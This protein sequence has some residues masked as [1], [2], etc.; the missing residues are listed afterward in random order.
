[1]RDGLLVQ[2]FPGME[3]G[4]AASFSSLR[5]EGRYNANM[6]RVFQSVA[7]RRFTVEEYHRMAETGIL[8]PDER[9]EL[10]RGFI[11][12][13][14]PKHWSHVMASKFVYDLLRDA[15]RGRVSVY[16]EAPLSVEG[17]DSEPEPDVLV[18]SNPDETAYQSSRTK[19]LLVVEVA[20]F[21][22]EY[23]LGEKASLY[24]EAD[25][26]E[27]WVV[28]LIERT[29]VEFRKPEKGSYQDRTELDESS[30]VTTG[31]W[32]DLS[33]PVAAFLPPS[34][35]TPPDEGR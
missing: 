30:P 11:R 32:S 5:D 4:F 21:S 31:A 24:A 17:T 15:L 22:L 2:V 20:D 1:M 35:L 33:F 16:Q 8:G 10:V 29:L 26:P 23:D 25:V 14:S 12:E 28:N 6:S 27:Y 3:G 18:C 34:M 13:M 19:P 7:Q 9:V